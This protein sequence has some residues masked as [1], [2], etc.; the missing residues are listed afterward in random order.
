MQMIVDKA[1]LTE[2]FI[3]ISVHVGVGIS[4]AFSNCL[5]E[6]HLSLISKLNN[7]VKFSWQHTFSY[8]AEICSN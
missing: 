8:L 2:E 7:S 1:N 3:E 4:T 5:I 6:T